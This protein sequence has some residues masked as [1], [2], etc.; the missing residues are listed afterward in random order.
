MKP[1]PPTPEEQAVLDLMDRTPDPEI[2]EAQRVHR[3]MK[4]PTARTWP[5]AFD[6]TLLNPKAV[7][8]IRESVESWRRWCDEWDKAVAA[9]SHLRRVK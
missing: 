7:L 9:S 6:L 8:T 5:E 2:E 1:R 3:T 4:G